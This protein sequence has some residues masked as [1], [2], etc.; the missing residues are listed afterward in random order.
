MHVRRGRIA[1]KRQPAASPKPTMPA[2]GTAMAGRVKIGG[3]LASSNKHHLPVT[4]ARFLL[5]GGKDTQQQSP[6]KT[7]AAS[8]SG[9]PSAQMASGKSRRRI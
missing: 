4:L 8:S 1:N 7:E 3:P 6:K 9:G 5:S 2:A